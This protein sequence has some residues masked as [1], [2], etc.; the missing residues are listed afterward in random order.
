M[1][2]KVISLFLVCIAFLFGTVTSNSSIRIGL[3]AP[4]KLNLDSG[5]RYIKS[6]CEAS[7]R[8]ASQAGGQSVQVQL[9]ADDGWMIVNLENFIKTL[10]DVCKGDAEDADDAISDTTP[11]YWYFFMRVKDSSVKCVEGVLLCETPLDGDLGIKSRGRIQ[12]DR[13]V[14]SIVCPIIAL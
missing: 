9:Y 3:D 2:P 14:R 13:C 1:T 6:S 7:P 12:G 11:D 8:T 10:M 5:S 4:N